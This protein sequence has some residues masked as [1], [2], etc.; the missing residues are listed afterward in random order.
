MLGAVSMRFLPVVLALVLF[1]PLASA[2]PTNGGSGNNG[3]GGRLG[4]VSGGLRGG[5]GGGGGDHGGGGR[6][7]P[8]SPDR[9]HHGERGVV[10]VIPAGMVAGG[11][12]EGGVSVV[13]STPRPPDGG[14]AHFEGYIGAHKVY[15]S[16]GAFSAELGIR[17]RLFRIG[18]SVTRY[19]ERQPDNSQLTLTVPALIGGIRIDGGGPTRAYLELGVVNS[20]THNDPVMDTSIV[21][22]LGGIRLEHP[23]TDHT[24]VV[25]TA[26][27]MV[28][29]GDIRAH[30]ITAGVRWGALQ[31]SF[32]V[33]D[34]N[35][36]PALYGPELGLRF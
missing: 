10:E 22:G 32:R 5:G 12:V 35:V 14:R 24:T 15:E 1:E 11:V 16:D 21:G 3:G 8:A 20:K 30:A 2:S 17:D 23:L 4:Q 34:Y 26:H 7:P 18:V 36:G 6:T 27:E 31:A 19:Y 25:G 28:F 33:L 29:E 13:P 9:E